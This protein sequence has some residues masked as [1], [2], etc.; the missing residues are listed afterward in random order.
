MPS[1][2]G[3][4]CCTKLL[5]LPLQ[6]N[7]CPD[8][9]AKNKA[10]HRVS[11]ERADPEEFLSGKGCTKERFC[12]SQAQSVTHTR[13]PFRSWPGGREPLKPINSPI[14]RQGPLGSMPDP[15]P[16]TKGIA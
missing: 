9:P 4:T 3:R 6:G 5:K 2:W 7:R 8:P 14:L 11:Q 1:A 13:V 12:N 15:A 10:Y 16:T